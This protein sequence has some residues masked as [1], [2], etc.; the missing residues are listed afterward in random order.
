MSI[1]SRL[2]EPAAIPLG[3]KA[4]ACFDRLVEDDEQRFGGPTELARKRVARR[5]QPAA[6][7]VLIAELRRVGLVA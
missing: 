1:T 7:S 4:R 6:E 3:T 2:V 5:L